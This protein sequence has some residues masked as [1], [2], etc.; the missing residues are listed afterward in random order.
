MTDADGGTDQEYALTRWLTSP[1]H[2]RL[3]EWRKKWDEAGFCVTRAD[4]QTAEQAL[5]A[6]YRAA[7]LPAPRIV[8]CGSPCSLLVTYSMLKLPEAQSVWHGY[9]ADVAMKTRV[10]PAMR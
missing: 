10:P 7:D 8:W 4:R 3:K 6:M 9:S 2:G 5:V 1:E